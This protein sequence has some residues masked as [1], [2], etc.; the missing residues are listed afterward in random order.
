MIEVFK[1]AV[2]N[3]R[4]TEKII[5]RLQIRMPGAIV[6]FDLEDCD[7]VM[8]LRHGLIDVLYIYEVFNELKINC[9]ILK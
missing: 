7:K 9:E 5:D 2:K 8:R 3:K 1:T 6:S 4:D